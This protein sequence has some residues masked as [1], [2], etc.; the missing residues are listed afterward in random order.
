MCGATSAG[1]AAAEALQ[2][3]GAS[4][5][6]L[7]A[8]RGARLTVRWRH[9]C[10]RRRSGKYSGQD[11]GGIGALP[12]LAGHRKWCCLADE[13]AYRAAHLHRLVHRIAEHFVDGEDREPRSLALVEA[14][15]SRHGL[16]HDDTKPSTAELLN[17]VAIEKSVRAPDLHI[18]RAFVLKAPRCADH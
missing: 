9:A 7:L 5:G 16:K 10:P 18:E 3:V 6:Y 11:N 13:L 15:R 8:G 1:S 17:R 4:E 14:L 12:P 2:K